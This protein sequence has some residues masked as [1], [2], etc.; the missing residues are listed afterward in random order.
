MSYL[1]DL[2]GKTVLVTGAASGIGLAT[3]ERFAE[4]GATVALNHLE[5]D[6]RGADEINRLQRAGHHVVAAQGNVSD[7]E[8][9]RRMVDAVIGQLGSLNY[10]I[11]NAGTAGPAVAGPI[12]PSQ[13]AEMTEDVWSLILS[14]NLLGAFRCAS[15]AAEALKSTGG[16][17]CNT[18]PVAGIHGGGSS[19]AYAVSKAGLINLT[20][21]LARALAPTVRVNAVAPGLVETPWTSTWPAAGKEAYVEQTMLR[22]PCT[23]A[24]VA[25]VIYFLCVDAA[26][27]TGQTIMV[28]GGRL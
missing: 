3:V 1:A 12:A 9:A 5:S 25:A 10:L 28:D 26:M 16:A 14:T 8:D 7:A 15:A 24:D 2:S 20:N 27:V 11:N 4:A 13:L 18:A 19:I 17:V 21:G 23:P 6:Q 22:R